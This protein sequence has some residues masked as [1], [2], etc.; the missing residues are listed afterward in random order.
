MARD[1]P[2]IRGTQI[3]LKNPAV[4]DQIKAQMRS[5]QFP[6]HEIGCRV[7]GIRDLEGTYHVREGHHR[8]A[9]AMELY[10][11]TRDSSFVRNL[12]TSGLWE[13]WEYPPHDS[14]PLPSRSWWGA[15]RNRLNL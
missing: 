9:A 5:G 14:R 12:L 2:T 15:F 7:R 13:E 6:Y 11:E 4:V 10:K 1:L 8:I 3:G